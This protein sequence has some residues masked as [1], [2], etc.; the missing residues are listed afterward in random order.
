MSFLTKVP[1]LG[2]FS[3]FFFSF[4][5]T[6][7]HTSISLWDCSRVKYSFVLTH[8]QFACTAHFLPWWKKRNIKMEKGAWKDSPVFQPLLQAPHF[9]HSKHSRDRK[10]HHSRGV[11]LKTKQKKNKHHTPHLFVPNLQE[12][13][14]IH[15]IARV[16]RDHLADL[17][18]LQRRRHHRLSG[19]SLPVLCYLYC[20]E[21]L[22]HIC[23]ELPMFWFLA[24]APFPMLNTEKCLASCYC[25]PH[26]RYL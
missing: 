17:E 8:F 22:P 26:F 15:I 19:Q 18:C 2:R 21:I 4:L 6:S 16:E 7:W 5:P 1:H 13:W 25:L 14:G 23:V 12:Y 3:D 9:H 10:D 20:K 11:C 24:V